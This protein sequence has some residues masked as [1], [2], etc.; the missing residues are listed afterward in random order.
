VT[1]EAEHESE[2]D[3][4]EV[5][6]GTAVGEYVVKARIGVGGFGSVFRA[7]HPVIGKPA[8][9]KV[10]NQ[11]F[12][13]NP[14]MVSRFIDEARAVNRIKHKGIVDIFA[15]G[16]LPD[17]RQY[18]VMEL[19][20][21]E[22][23]DKYL[24]RV[25]RVSPAEALPILRRIA[26]ALDAAHGQQIAHR[27]LKP[28]NVFLT[29]D[30]EGSMTPKL[31]DFGIAKLLGDAGGMSHKTRT[32]TPIGTPYYMSPEQ[33]HGKAVDHR[34]DIYSLGV[35]VF[36]MLTGT[37]P[38]EGES[39]ME[40]MYKH[41]AAEAPAVSKAVPELPAELDEPVRRMMAK[42]PA[43]RPESA[44]A[45]VQELAAACEAGGVPLVAGTSAPLP[46][47][48]VPSGRPVLAAP[49]KV[50]SGSIVDA[51][52]VA[53]PS[54]TQLGASASSRPPS[55]QGSPPRKALAG[56]AVVVAAALA[57][58][59]VWWATRP[60]SVA[61]SGPPSGASAG[62]TREAPVVV[63]VAESLSAGGLRAPVAPSA[64]SIEV[65]PIAAPA[66]TTV[67]VSFTSAV[68]GEVFDGK[69]RLGT[70]DDTLELPKGAPVKLTVRAPGFAPRE[71]P[72][73]A[74]EDRT[75]PVTL[76]RAKSEVEW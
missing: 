9:V 45:A 4:P 14:Q 34:T 24:D 42:D 69:K 35:M 41:T 61:A 31:L 15:F 1:H 72:V 38:F 37:L 70:T 44:T 65:A 63:S 6:V 49:A 2:H 57:G 74:S 32:G 19:L 71:V 60:P 62:A 56:G 22:P 29:F 27:D 11:Q 33:C 43:A 10:L 39:L 8:A 23:L 58:G 13:A 47:S 48:Q 25:G 21:G 68:K 59:S 51:R 30:D 17:G 76:V 73:D 64:G 7:E 26:R 20:E 50:V 3:E 12:S 16:K 18:L 40:I 54:Q 53:G 46:S 66:A 36:Q 5:A 75:V 28:E 55:H 52:T 67:K